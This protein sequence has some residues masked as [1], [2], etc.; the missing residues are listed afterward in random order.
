MGR[1]GDSDSQVLQEGEEGVGH[2]GMAGD[3]V[4]DLVEQQED[5]GLRRGEH[6]GQRVGP[7][8]RGLGG[9]AQLGDALVARDLT[10]QVDPGRLPPFRGVPGAAGEDADP[11]GGGL[12]DACIA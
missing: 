10:R 11:S 8:R 4:Q 6:P 2:A 5:R 12:S 7:R 9:R 3:E 1:A